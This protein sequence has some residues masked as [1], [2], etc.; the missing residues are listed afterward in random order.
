MYGASTAPIS[1]HHRRPYDSEDGQVVGLIE[2]VEAGAF[3]LAQSSQ[4]RG[5]IGDGLRDDIEHMLVRFVGRDCS[6]AI[7]GEL[8]KIEH[9]R[10]T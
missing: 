7:G 9:S 3:R 10:P 6:P 8:L 5:R 4:H 2:L 1:C